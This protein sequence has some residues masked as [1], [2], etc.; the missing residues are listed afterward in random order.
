MGSLHTVVTQGRSGVMFRLT[1]PV[2]AVTILALVSMSACGGGGGDDDAAADSDDDV[3]VEE[4]SSGA[5]AADLGPVVAA[6]E[7]TGYDC[8][9]ESFVMTSAIRETCLTTTSVSLSAYAW[10]DA[11]TMAAEADSELFCTLDSGLGELASVRGDV[12]AISAVS[13]SGSNTPETKAAIDEVLTGLA[14]SLGGTVV[15]TPCA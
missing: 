1:R 14:E 8:T 2:T 12:W 11:A 13:L 15:S 6:I 10:S 7:A 9:P 5:G 3:V 4:V